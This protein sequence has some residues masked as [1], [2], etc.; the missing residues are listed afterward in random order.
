[1]RTMMA[2]LVL[3]LGSISVAHP[4]EAD[5]AA[6]MQAVEDYCASQVHEGFLTSGTCRRKVMDG[7]EKGNCAMYVKNQ[8]LGTYVVDC[9]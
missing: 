4:G 2:S 9:K 6:M 1:M 5:M 7:L 3:V 8:T